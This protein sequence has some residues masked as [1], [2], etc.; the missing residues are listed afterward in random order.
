[1]LQ[2][3]RDEYDLSVITWVPVDF[4][5]MNRYYGTDLR[6]TDLE[7]LSCPRTMRA[8]V[9]MVPLPLHHLKRAFIAREVSRLGVDFDMIV[10]ANNEMDLGHPAIQYV[11]FPAR[12]LP[13]P[14]VDL[15]WYHR[16]PGTVGGYHGL[17]DSLSFATIA[18]IRRNLTLT[19]SAWTAAIYR[20]TYGSDCEVRVLPP[21]VLGRRSPFAWEERTDDC[22]CIGRIS[23]EKRVDRIVAMM[24]A[25]RSRGW[26]GTLHLVGHP[27]NRPYWR[28]I[29]ALIGS[30][31]WIRVHFDIP[32]EDLL[33]LVTRCRYGIHGM[34]DEHFGISIAEMAIAGCVVFIP[35]G[36]GQVEIVD[37]DPRIVYDCEDDGV[38]KIERVLGD[39]EMQREISSSLVGK[40]TRFTADAFMES[41]RVL[42]AEFAARPRT[43]RTTKS[44]AGTA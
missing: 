30:K 16:F 33:D 2:A 15:R 20:Q 22:V 25:I 36:G 12:F 8:L 19:N 34:L 10:T 37:S 28:K 44:R 35:D 5:E 7:M 18:G 9:D 1:M 4:A 42:V 6:E 38:A 43:K 21:P 27:D 11:H 26:S 23:P 3:L 40:G 14:K 39:P 13:R 32:R 41:A 29:Q 24:S 31:E 17:V